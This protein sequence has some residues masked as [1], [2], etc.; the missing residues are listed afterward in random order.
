MEQRENHLTALKLEQFKE[1][2][3]S[4]QIKL[5]P[6]RLLIY[7]KNS[8]RQMSILPTDMLYQRQ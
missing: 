8:W 4:H 7:M 3:K 2:Y 6:Q 1:T 5:T